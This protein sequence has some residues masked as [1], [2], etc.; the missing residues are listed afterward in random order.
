MFARKL[1]IR[2]VSLDTADMTDVVLPLSGLTSVVGLD[3]DS[4]TDHVYWTDV[5]TDSISRARWDG[6]AQQVPPSL[7]V[8]VSLCLS[9]SLSAAD[10]IAVI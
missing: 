7:S 3:F 2:R 1:D 6:T 4:Q 10:G 9:V 5:A 8:S